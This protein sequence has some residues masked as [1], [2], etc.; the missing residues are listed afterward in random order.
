MSEQ[1]VRLVGEAFKRSIATGE[2]IVIPR[3]TAKVRGSGIEIDR[4]DWLV[5]EQGLEAAGLPV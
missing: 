5:R 3:M 4:K 2:V 1:A